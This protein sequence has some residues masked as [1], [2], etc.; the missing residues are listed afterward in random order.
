MKKHIRMRR[1][2]N[3]FQL[4]FRARILKDLISFFDGRREFQISLKN[5]RNTDCLLL[6]M[7]LR[8]RLEELFSEVREGMKSLTIEQIKEVL[9]IEV[10]K[11]IDHSKHVF[12][13]TNKYNEFKKKESLENISSREEKLKSMLSEDLKTYKK[14]IDSRLESI[15]QSMD[16]EVNAKSV[17]YKQLRMSFIDLYLMRFEWMRE[18]INLTGKEEDDFRR[19][20][21]EKL[22]MN[23]FPE[24]LD[25]R[26]DTNQ[27]PTPP[28]VSV[29]AQLELNSL[30][31]TPISECIVGFLEEKGGV[32]LRTTS[33]F[34]LL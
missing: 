3:Q 23:L 8:I 26:V 7:T 34:K 25:Q 15:L 5:V 28:Q 19:E 27:I 4:H 9:R 12:Y 13:D 10:N 18:L 2:R 32:S 29:S 22:K 6:T 11:Q 1:F 33:I 20:V 31:S 21:D 14:K 30:E 17:N 16:I 24:L